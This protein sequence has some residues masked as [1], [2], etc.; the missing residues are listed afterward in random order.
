MDFSKLSSA[1]KQVVYAAAAVVVLGIVALAR[2]WGGLV[3]LPLLGGIG[4]L[5]VVFM[6]QLAPTTKL[7]GSKGSLLLICGGVAGVFWLLATLTWLEY[8]FRFLVTFDTILFLLGLAA[9][10]WLAWLSWQAFQ[11]E[12]GKFVVGT[13]GD[14]GGSSAAAATPPPAEPAPPP[15]APPP[16]AEPMTPREPMAPPSE[17]MAPREPM[18]PPM[19]DEGMPSA[20][21]QPTGS[22]ED[23]N[24]A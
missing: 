14:A 3:F 7:P 6:P 17:P 21:S 19:A 24:R 8:I 15:A 5:A 20:P 16:A 9:S 2:A 11:A 10:L 4:A 22:T 23:E 12:G 18:T 1:D 13:S